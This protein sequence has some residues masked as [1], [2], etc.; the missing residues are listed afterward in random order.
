MNFLKA[1]RAVAYNIRVSD[2][3]IVADEKKPRGL[4]KLKMKILLITVI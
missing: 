1:K 3:C 2:K 4:T